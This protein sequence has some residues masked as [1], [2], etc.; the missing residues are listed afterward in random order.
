[1]TSISREKPVAMS[2]KRSRSLSAVAI[3]AA[4]FFAVPCMAD[5][6]SA[7]VAGA[8]AGAQA[9]APTSHVSCKA[10]ADGAAICKTDGYSIDATGCGEGALY[11]RIMTDGGVDLNQSVD[12]KGKVVAHL[13]KGQFVCSAG[14]AI[15]SETTQ[16]FVVAVETKTV[17]D[18][19]GNDL[20]KNG[21]HAVAWKEPRPTGT[22][23]PDVDPAKGYASCAAGWINYGDLDQYANGLKD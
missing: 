15:S 7:R 16:H 22:C 9:I 2:N 20:C 21:D 13:E 10:N 1:M 8:L 17:A 18:C 12:G 14:H 11:G 5:E 3:L 19:K 23:N 6:T 4:T